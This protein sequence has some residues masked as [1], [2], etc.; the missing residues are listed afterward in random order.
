[1]KR[2]KIHEIYFYG[3]YYTNYKYNIKPIYWLRLKDYKVIDAKDALEKGKVKNIKQLRESYI[4]FFK[5]DMISLY[6]EFVMTFCPNDQ[7]EIIKLEKSNPEYDYGTAFRYYY[8]G[9]VIMDMWHVYEKHRLQEDA[10]QWCQS[11]GL[12][13]VR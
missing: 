5:T 11:N 8:D 12:I 1:M 7:P 4:P 6:K 10:V 13:W 9:T 3:R 2:L